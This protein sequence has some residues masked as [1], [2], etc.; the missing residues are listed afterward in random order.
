MIFALTVLLGLTAA[1]AQGLGQVIVANGSETN[2]YVPIWGYNADAYQRSQ[3][4]YPE[5]MLT[6]LVG[7]EIHGI[8]YY[9][10]SAPS[11]SWEGAY[12]VKIG[13]VTE[14]A[15]AGTDFADVSSFTTV[16]TGEMDGS[17]GEAM[18]INFSSTFTYT[19]GNLLIE[20]SETSG[21]GS[22]ASASFYGIEST[23]ASLYGY[24]SSSV[25][26]ISGSTTNFI[27][28]TGFIVPVSCA[29]PTIVSVAPDATTAVLTF[30]ENGS[31]TSWLLKI[32]DGS[33]LPITASPYTISGL[34]ASTDYT[35][36][37]RSLCGPGDT[38]FAATTSFSTSCSIEAFPY[39]EDF[40]SLSSGL[41]N[42]WNQEASS[43]SS[44]T[45]STDGHADNCLTFGDWYGYNSRL[46]V[47]AIDCSSLT[48]DGMLSFYYKNPD[49]G[50][51][52]NATLDLYYR[53]SSSDDW[54]AISEWS[55]ASATEDWT[56]AEVLLPNSANAA[57]YQI[58]MVAT[59]A[60][61]YP[62]VYVYIDDIN[63]NVPPS[64]VSPSALTALAI[65]ATGATL[66]WTENGS[67]T[68]WLLKIGDGEYQSIT[69]NPYPLSNLTPN[70]DYTVY[71]RSYCGGTDTSNATSFTFHTECNSFN[72]PFSEGFES[73]E[74]DDTPECWNIDGTYCY[75]VEN[76]YYDYAS[77]GTKAL[78][79]A[80]NAT[81]VTPIINV[82]GSDVYVSFDMQISNTSAG[83][84]AVGFAVSP[85]MLASAVYFDTIE[86]TET[87]T[88]QSFE[89]TFQNLLNIQSGCIVFKQ[90]ESTYYYYSI[91]VDNIKVSTPPTCPKPS[92]L[93]ATATET[94]LTISWTENGSAS[95]WL[96][97][98][99]DNDYRTVTENP[100]TWTG[101]NS[102][103][104]YAVEVRA[105]CGEG[106][107]SEVL[108]G[109]FATECSVIA[110][111][112]LPYFEGFEN[113][114]NCWNQEIVE[115][116]A[117]WAI[118]AASYYLSTYEG[119]N[120]IALYGQSNQSTRLISPVFDLTGVEDASLSFA[121][122]QPAWYDDVDSLIVQ[123]RLSET[124][125][126]QTLATY[127]EA[128]EAWQAETISLPEVSATFQFAFLGGLLYANGIGIDSITLAGVAPV[129][130]TCDVPTAVAVS[131]IT[132]TTATISWTGTASEYQIQVT[133]GE[134]PIQL[135]VSAS[136]YTVEGLA[137]GTDYAV[138]VRA[139][140]ENDTYS[141][142]S[143]EVSFTTDTTENPGPTGI[144]DVNG[145]FSLNIYPNPTTS[146]ATIALDGVSG[147]LRV[148]VVDMSGR[149]V[150]SE[151]VEC[152][153]G[154]MK[155]LNVSNLSQ[156]SYFVRV[157]GQEVSTVK[158]L[159]IR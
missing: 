55:L 70:T 80:D 91:Y 26:A 117:E 147:S 156:G 131:N 82:N 58:S 56:L 5:S 45:N 108:A 49:N 4:I 57:Y 122:M 23:A 87:Y 11:R 37:L 38:S 13:T 6:D 102:S 78:R 152:N 98:V 96:V 125:E 2:S 73:L 64:C 159:I 52:D 30:T 127:S 72:L 93:D 141:D 153:E 46:I 19:G 20:V 47:P 48:A 119:S 101:L 118:N 128:V 12:E 143:A 90:L 158:K 53:T 115:G 7:K 17:A 130:V 74:A 116:S 66:S 136:P 65:T 24:S 121:H 41:P 69:T 85:S 50:G 28:K 44:W 113:G 8:V 150:L 35:I 110:A 10:S 139:V 149:I 104:V 32:N 33:Y 135:T 99:G 18:T 29:D 61:T 92:A 124:S 62:K 15:F 109:S 77:E 155:Q 94:S 107:T 25:A 60:D 3:T 42:C 67:A 34:T 75:V 83:K 43:S 129:V 138:S 132:E 88:Y 111:A 51:G 68:E 63:V 59:G 9:I 148:D 81:A 97:K 76:G 86:L 79:L 89:Y 145:N 71:I 54:T 144:N 157:F 1:N 123:Y 31:A 106:D 14:S 137:E 95:Q 21:E 154:C 16:Y 103:S 142:W 105:F 133:G 114:I 112:S 22:W 84:L 146:S 120:Y 39:S 100:Y 27:P 36:S 134:Q 140:C 40:A 151:T 126:W